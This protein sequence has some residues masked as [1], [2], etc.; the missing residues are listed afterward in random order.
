LLAFYIILSVLLYRQKYQKR[1]LKK[2]GWLIR[3]KQ[4]AKRQILTRTNKTCYFYEAVKIWA[5]SNLNYTATLIPLTSP[6]SPWR[7][8]APQHGQENFKIQAFGV[9]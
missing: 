1:P 2:R 6:L 8:N 5:S 3:E 9:A 7:L 4:S